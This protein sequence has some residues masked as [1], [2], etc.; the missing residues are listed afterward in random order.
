MIKVVRHIVEFGNLGETNRIQ[1]PYNDCIPLL[2]YFAPLLPTTF[3]LKLLWCLNALLAVNYHE[4]IVLDLIPILRLCPQ[5]VSLHIHQDE[6]DLLVLTDVPHLKK[7]CLHTLLNFRFHFP[8]DELVLCNHALRNVHFKRLHPKQKRRSTSIPKLFLDSY[9]LLIVKDFF[10]IASILVA[11]MH[12]SK[13]G[14][15]STNWSPPTLPS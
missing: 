1:I 5:E 14:A 15:S 11:N 9:K 13:P 3:K 4:F 2:Q 6:A 12:H 10:N 7:L 8:D